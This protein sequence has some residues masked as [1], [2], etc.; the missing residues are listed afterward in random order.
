[1]SFAPIVI[2]AYNRPVHLQKTLNALALNQEAIE[3]NLYIFCDGP[4]PNTNPEN[5]KNINQV[6]K[7]AQT[8][9]R[10]KKV[11]V[12]VSDKNLGLSKSVINGVTKVIE[13]YGNI[14]VLED[15][16]IVGKHFLSF[17]NKGLEVYKNEERVYGVTGYCFPSSKQ[18]KDPT[19]FLP[20]MSSWGYATWVDRWNKIN[21]N[22]YELL[23][24]VQ[25]RNLQ[26]DLIFGHLN[27]FQ[28]LKDQVAGKNDSWAVRFYVS[29]HFNKGV[30]LFPNKPLLQNIGLDGSGL[31]CLTED[32]K[33]VN[34][35]FISTTNIGIKKLNIEIKSHIIKKI[36]RGNFKNNT[37]FMQLLKKKIRKAI[38]PEILQLIRRKFQF[39]QQKELNR[40]MQLPRFKQTSTTLLGKQMVVADGASYA[41]MFNEIFQEH[42]Y[43]FNTSN[44]TPYII[45]GGANIGMSTIYLK[46]QFPESKIVSFEPDEGIFKI[47]KKNIETFGFKDVS[48]INK[49]LWNEDTQLSFNSEGAD[50]GA[51]SFKDIKSKTLNTVKVVDLNPYLNQSVDFLKLDIEGA[52]TVV[53]KSIES[54]LHF[55]ERIFIEYHSYIDEE[56]TIGE[57]VEILKK[58]NFRLYISAGLSSKAP[59]VRVNTYRDMDMQLNIF[60]IKNK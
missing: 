4:K 46:T 23:K 39:K 37:A 21:F 44:R 26:S 1:M 48:L 22:G 14:I 29:M 5:L 40:L 31:H 8:E 17:I 56:Q 42:I 49:G 28:M 18:I 36:K 10:F 12:I 55:V 16:I 43:K 32:H 38:A 19:Y 52:E 59:F 60:G 13:A 2:F 35:N 33:T 7:I 54:N 20:I 9:E 51:I 25:D 41:F 45:D 30:F 6:V 53:L 57:I 11:N 24:E 47:F 27:Y 3:S 15:D 34:D 50:A 58:N